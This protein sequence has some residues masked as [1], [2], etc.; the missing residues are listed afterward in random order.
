MAASGNFPLT[1]IGYPPDSSY[2]T[3]RVD[4]TPTGED[5]PSTLT[6]T[7]TDLPSMNDTLNLGQATPINMSTVALSNGAGVQEQESDPFDVFGDNSRKEKDI[8][9]MNR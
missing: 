8:L 4:H 3:L 9:R 1:P 6:E 5:I 2:N 7:P